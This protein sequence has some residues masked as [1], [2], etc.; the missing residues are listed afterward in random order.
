[1]NSYRN[2]EIFRE[3]KRLAIEVHKVSLRLPKFELFEEGSQM[4]RSSKSVSSNIV[5]GFARRKYKGD[6]IKFLTYS[7]SECDE[8]LIHLEFCFETGSLTDEDKFNELTTGYIR[9]G[10][11]LNTFIQKIS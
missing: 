6:F 10:K 9:L 7:V 2:M 5:E 4:R 8:T 1:M 11:R 3:S